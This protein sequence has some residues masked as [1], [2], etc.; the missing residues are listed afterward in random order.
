MFRV[1]LDLFARSE[2]PVPEQNGFRQRSRII[3]VASRSSTGFAG[4]N[5]LPMMPHR[6]LDEWVGSLEIGEILFR[7]ECMLV[8]AGY[9]HPFVSHKE[10]SV[11]P[12]GKLS[13]GELGRTLSAMIPC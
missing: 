13:L 5:P 12:F 3:E 4:F 1:P 7:E 9:E 10:G 11:A 6:I 2:G 8:V